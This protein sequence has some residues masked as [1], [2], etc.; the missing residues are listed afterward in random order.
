MAQKRRGRGEG[1]VRLRADGRREASIAVGDGTRKSHYAK[2]QR[3]ALRWLADAR[4]AIEQ[5]AVLPDERQTVAAY[6]ATWLTEMG[7]SP[8]QAAR[9]QPVR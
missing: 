2:T 5:G 3:E 8:L 4:R 6:L 9:F 7:F 1:S